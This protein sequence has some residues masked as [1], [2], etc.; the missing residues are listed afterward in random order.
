MLRG[1]AFTVLGNP[2]LCLGRCSSFCGTGWL[3]GKRTLDHLF[4]YPSNVIAQL[5]QVLASQKGA[6][7]L[8]GLDFSQQE[9]H[10]TGLLFLTSQ[11]GM[12]DNEL[13]LPENKEIIH[14]CSLT[15]SQLFHVTLNWQQDHFPDDKSPLFFF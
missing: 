1:P 10:W 8:D 11:L 3:L 15:I 9:K 13:K 2:A 6:L 14:F 12:G 4:I 5:V 7:V